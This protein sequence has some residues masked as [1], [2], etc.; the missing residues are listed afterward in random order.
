MARIL[1]VDDEE[2]SALFFGEI[3]KNMGHSVVAAG[4]AAAALE[5]LE[6]NKPDLVLMDLE[7]PGMDGTTATREIK[8]NPGT[9]HIPVVIL[10]AHSETRAME[11][12]TFARADGFLNKQADHAALGAAVDR[13]LKKASG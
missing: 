8:K 6:S 9:A 5:L 11:E 7:M 4:S 3:L 12:V 13:A 10:T 1:I 2:M